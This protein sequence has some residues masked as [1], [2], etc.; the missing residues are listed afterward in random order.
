MTT[1]S[2]ANDDYTSW[3]GEVKKRIRSARLSV[4]RSVNCELILLYW[5][6]G[7]GIVEKQKTLGWGKSV[8][9]NLSGDLQLEFPGMRGFSADNLWR[10]RQFYN[11]YSSDKFLLQAESEVRRLKVV[12]F[13]EQAVP[14]IQGKIRGVDLEQAVPNLALT[15][16]ELVAV[17]P[18]GHHVEIMKKVPEPAARFYY[19]RATAQCGWTRKVLLNQI[20]A[21]AYERNLS[22]GKTHNFPTALP[23]HLAEQAEEALKSS[24]NLEFLGISREIHERELEDRLIEQLKDF[25]LELGYG[26]CFIG[27]QYRLLLSRKE[28]FIDLLFYHRFL[29]C[30]V[31]IDLK[32]GEFE[33][34]Y[35]GKMDFYLNLLDQRQLFLPFNDN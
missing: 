15:V 5:D 28:Y 31:A 35:A 23:K 11:E 18:W 16:R 3:L 24:Y 12:G 20:K 22:Q 1:H 26:F 17:V 21:N 27:R 2:T 33:P 25:V 4:A 10:M 7:Q 32:I 14:E 34:E 8:V 9:Q 30:L 6:I 29:K 19:L 13:L